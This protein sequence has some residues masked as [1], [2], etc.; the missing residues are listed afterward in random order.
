MDLEP[1]PG[2]PVSIRMYALLVHMQIL[3]Y[4]SENLL[5]KLKQFRFFF[6]EQ[7]DMEFYTISLASVAVVQNW[8]RVKFLRAEVI[9]FVIFI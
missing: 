1:H 3:L 5:S 6:W 7:S 9:L 4:I 2:V 8:G